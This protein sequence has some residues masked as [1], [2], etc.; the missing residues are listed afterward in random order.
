ML[1]RF[2]VQTPERQLDAF[3]S[4]YTPEIA[5]LARASLEKLRWQLPGAVELVYD[6]YNALAIG[7]APSTKPSHAVVSLALYPRWVSLFLLQGATLPDPAGLLKGS[8]SRVRH[9]VLDDAEVLDRPEVRALVAAAAAGSATPFSTGEPGRVII[10]SI[11]SRQRPRR[12]QKV[13]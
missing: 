3:I 6:N 11:S 13:R 7:F 5:A 8:G 9:L 1:R 10:Q 4:R 12:P 2:E